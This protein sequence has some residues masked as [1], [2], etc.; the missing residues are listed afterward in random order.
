ML[1]D[2]DESDY[3]E[4]IAI[5]QAAVLATHH[6][7]DEVEILKLKQLI[8]HTYFDNVLLKGMTNSI[9]QLIGFIGTKNNKIEM[10]FVDPKCHGEGVGTNLCQHAIFEQGMTKVDV[11]EQN[12]NAVIFY[13]KMGFDIFDRS[14]LDSE[15]NPY[16]FCI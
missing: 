5:W 14:D 16:L 6:F 15:G 8:L 1:I 4:L 13:Q 10:L 3:P 11:N 7:L 9:D 12:S 2:V